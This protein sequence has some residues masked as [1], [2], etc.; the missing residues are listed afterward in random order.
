MKKLLLFTAFVSVRVIYCALLIISF[1]TYL[2]AQ[3]LSM[4]VYTAKEGLPATN[5]GRIYQDKLGYLWVSTA[6][7]SCR[8]DGKSF[9]Y[10]SLS[11]LLPGT[12]SAMAFMDSRMRY[13]AITPAGFV[14]YRRNKFISYPYSDSLGK[15]LE[16]SNY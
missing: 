7:G 4:R 13:W 10:D 2:Q 15:R 9:T 12:G 16:L 11:D 5:V 14:E 6:E 1:T 3:E 8:F